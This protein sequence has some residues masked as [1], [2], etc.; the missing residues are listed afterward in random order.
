MGEIPAADWSWINATA[1]RFER[2]WK[3]GLRPR[4][5]DYL[6]AADE[7]RRPWLLEELLRVEWD[8]R[9][10]DDERSTPEDY[11]RRFPDYRQVVTAV[12]A[13]GLAGTEPSAGAGRSRSLTEATAADR[14]PP[15]SLPPELANHPDYQI[16][17][18][19][20]RGGMGMVYLAHNRILGRDEVLKVIAREIIEVPGVLDRFQ[21]EIRAVAGLEHPNIVTAYSA[22]RA[23]GGLVFAME[24]V[25][26]LDLARLVKAK[27]PLPVAN[28]CNYAHQAALG[29]QHAHEAGLVH[30]DI[31]PGNLMLTSD[32][33]RA[34]IKVLDFGLAKAGRE[35]A[36]IELASSGAGGRPGAGGQTTRTGEMLGTPDFI[37][38][39]QIS[40][41]Q[42]ADI[43]ADIYSLGCTLYY[44]LAGRAPFRGDDFSAVLHSHLTETARP[45]DLVRPEVPSDVAALVARTMA[46][47]PAGRFGTP[48]EVA[49]ALT[50]FFRKAEATRATT[51][52]GTA[53]APAPAAVPPIEPTH[54]ATG[55]PATV[56][57]ATA[58]ASG[59]PGSS[60]SDSIAADPTGGHDKGRIPAAASPIGDRL[61]WLWPAATAAAGAVALGLMVY[62]L[63]I[64]SWR[65]GRPPVIERPRDPAPPAV[66]DARDEPAD[67]G[68]E[69]GPVPPGPQPGDEGNLPKTTKIASAK[70]EGE[71]KVVPPPQPPPQPPA[72]KK[73]VEAPP[74]PAPQPKPVDVAAA[75]KKP[76]EVTPKSP[77]SERGA[78]VDRAI[79]D[80]ARYLKSHQRDDGSWPDFGSDARSGTTSL[81]TLALLTAGEKTD[82]ETIRKSL[83][84][85][86]KLRPEDLRSTYAIGL[87]TMV[88]AAAEP[89]RDKLRIADNVAWL[90]RAQIK[91]GDPV[92]WPGSWTYTDFKR[93]NHGDNSNTSFAL[94]GLHAASEVG[95]PV[96]PEVW[97]LARAYW[98]R[99]Q[100]ADGSWA[101]TPDSPKSTA[102]MTCAG[103]SS[104]IISG[105]R[106]FQGQEFLQGERIQ[107]C[108][109]GGVN[110]SLAGGINWLA[111]NFHVDQ[112]YGD[113]QQWKFYYLHDLEHAGRL[114]SIRYFGP[115]DWYRLGAEELMHNQDKLN[116]S[117]QGAL[118]ERDPIL[119][120]SFALLFLAKGRAP[121]LINKLRHA[122]FADWNND[123]DDVR[124]I[125]AI[126]SRD[127]KTP[128]TWQVVDPEHATVEDL[129]R[130][131]LLF[132]NGHRVP[133]FSAEARRNIRAYIDRG[134]CL[135][136][137]ACCGEAEFDQ[138]FRRLMKDIFPEE[139]HQLRPLLPGNPVWQVRNLLSPEAHPL[140]GILHDGRFAV[141]YSPKDLSCYWNQLEHSPANPAAIKAVKIGQNVIDY[142]TGRKPPPDKLSFP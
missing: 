20:G 34:V 47:D 111:R 39:E 78:Q 80:G 27:G 115:H 127:W 3:A 95:V 24:Y 133:E 107:N 142:L 33:R 51:G 112:N 57:V 86:R 65:G 6:A 55:I 137:D 119:A 76:V 108:G 130:A 15:R 129:L 62:L 98:E 41:S 13:G 89:E 100:K 42:S 45:L 22:F 120:T 36:A 93:G 23:A 134:G 37:A 56:P 28:A 118:M 7:S 74:A 123:P 116:G 66:V 140:S 46:R 44:L 50:P 5:E 102:S 106:R 48:A 61:R 59:P 40:D 54:L 96:K 53:P 91:P 31:K 113:G 99:S 32:G 79:R 125:V 49:V 104:L 2:A 25:E 131:P 60:G 94:L 16:I 12:F 1:D 124:N 114:A 4:I 109:K 21:R 105:L 85:L 72:A 138:G 88:F 75:A 58:G 110:R 10:G 19:L 139:P 35:Q 71:S 83:E 77:L 17:R 81:V 38:P 64:H 84:L 136:A 97:A 87:Q 122:P 26:G 69:P 132:F 18:R 70:P 9:E 29:L 68:E 121:V 128:L 141:I 11:L 8:L 117:W 90:Q 126:V 73:E 92:P 103:V 82:S 52:P 67:P 43:R 63:V 101:Y 30:R 135:F 14:G